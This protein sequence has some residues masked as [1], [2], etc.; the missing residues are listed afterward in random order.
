MIRQY[1]LGAIGLSGDNSVCRFFCTA[2]RFAPLW[3]GNQAGLQHQQPVSILLPFGLFFAVSA[4]YHRLFYTSFLQN[5]S[6]SFY[7]S[8]A[9]IC[10]QSNQIRSSVVGGPS[11]AI[12]HFC[13]R[14]DD[15][16]FLLANRN[17]G[18]HIVCVLLSAI[19]QSRPEARLNL[20]PVSRGTHFG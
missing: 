2:G 13:R 12:N 15:I 18:G 19:S 10:M 17:F 11:S 3:V 14:E 1:D 6:V 7:L 8:L 9:F 20:T 16:H 5:M 4:G